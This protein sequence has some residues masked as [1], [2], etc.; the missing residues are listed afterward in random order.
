MGVNADIR[1]YGS[2]IQSRFECEHECYLYKE[3]YLKTHTTDCK[4]ARRGGMDFELTG[5][6]R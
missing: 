4:L 6:N 3:G 1:M 5:M 2:I